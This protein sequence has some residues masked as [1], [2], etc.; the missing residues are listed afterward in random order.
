MPSHRFRSQPTLQR[1]RGP[2]VPAVLALSLI[3]VV[4]VGGGALVGRFLANLPE[5][6]PIAQRAA[7][8]DRPALAPPGPV[9]APAETPPPALAQAAT[10]APVEPAARATQARTLKVRA[11]AP[12]THAPH[13]SGFP[14]A[15]PQTPREQWEQQRIDYE[16]ARA[17]YDANER[18]EGYRWAQQNKVRLARYC[19]AAAQPDAF[20]EGCMTFLRPGRKRSAET[21]PAPR[22]ADEG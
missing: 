13:A 6:R 8:S 17:A 20:V 16:I 10:A 11:L 4:G 3:G 21:P 12:A 15:R 19:H 22:S 2:A 1:S 18:Q 9:A 14:T 7:P 5:A